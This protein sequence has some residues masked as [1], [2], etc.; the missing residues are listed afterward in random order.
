VDGR[1]EIKMRPAN[2]SLI[3]NEK[4]LPVPYRRF[5][6]W[7]LPLFFGSGC[8]ALI[9]EIVWLQLL[10][11]V[12]G[13]SGVSLAVLLGTFMGGMFLGSLLLPRV[14]PTRT[15]PL[16]IYAL[17][18]FG[19]ALAGMLVLCG[20]PD[21]ARFYEGFYG[22]GVFA[23]ALVATVCLLPPTMLMGAT[24]PAAARFVETSPAGVSWMGF[25]YGSNIAGAVAGCFLAGFLLLRLFDMPTATYVAAAV[26]FAVAV[27]ALLL[28]GRTPGAAAAASPDEIPAAGSPGFCL[29]SIAIAMSGLSALGAEVVWTRLLS[30]L[31]GGT[32]YSFSI[33]L[34]VFLFGM[35]LGSGCGSLLARTTSNARRALGIC[36]M[37]LTGAIAWAA[38]VISKSLPYWPVNPSIYTNDGGPWHLFQLDI[39]RAAWMVLPASLLWGASFPLAIAA[40]ATGA[41]DSGRMVGSVYAANTLGAILGSLA[42]SMVVIP[43]LGTLWAERLLILTAAAAAVVALVSSLSLKLPRDEKEKTRGSM[44][45]FSAVVTVLSALM[46]VALLVDS[47]SRVPWMMIAWGRFSALYMAQASP[48]LI[49][50]SAEIPG[51]KSPSKWYCSYVGEGMNASVAVTRT[52]SGTR[53]FHGAGKVQA[54]SEPQDMRLQRML[55]HLSALTCKNPDAVENVLVIACGAGVTAGSF[56]PYP[57]IKDIVICDIEP[58][59]PRVIAPMFG[60]ENHHVVDGIDKENPRFV[61]G[62]KV[63]VIY[64]DGRHYLRTLPRDIKFDIITSD[65]VDPWVKGSAALNTVEFY[66]MCKSHL[67][68]GGV[69]TQWVPM[70]ESDLASAKSMIGTFFSV[71]RDG[72][73]FSND[74][75]LEGYDGVLLG[76]ANPAGID[77]DVLQRILDRSDYRAVKESLCEAGF[78]P[79]SDHLPDGGVAV[80][81]LATYAGR[82]SDLCDWLKNAQ[83]NRDRNLRLQYLAGMRLNSYISTRILQSILSYYRFPGDVFAGSPARMDLLKQALFRQGRIQR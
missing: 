75:H 12:I 2:L 22:H 9:Y 64:D 36:Q 61:N 31:L 3:E 47:V 35:G 20:L 46:I 82:A 10:E 50:G 62:K 27:A 43:M 13:S 80:N 26:N 58:L 71:F 19:I 24:L 33:I 69:M 29:V 8:A 45:S 56:V 44:P 41:R 15:H 55:G 66:E 60:K 67:K 17:L 81:L 39:V 1:P 21:V 63:T 57:G 52:A 65:P 77:V 28:A 83:I 78:G 54:S 48:D 37:L 72:M 34:A 51:N 18:E 6:P 38:W 53:F 23:R 25:F 74:W 7:I 4:L 76:R 49:D 11:L 70:Y 5:L 40:V 68:P 30:L 42:F 16:R 79:R 59:V 32:V 14:V 73:I